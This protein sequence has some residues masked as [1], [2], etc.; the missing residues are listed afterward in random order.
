MNVLTLLRRSMTS[1][2]IDPSHL[3]AEH[4]NSFVLINPFLD[5]NGR[6]CRL[7]LNALLLKYKGVAVAFGGSHEGREEYFGIVRRASEDL[8]DDQSEFAAFI[9]NTSISRLRELAVKLQSSK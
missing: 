2:E 4:F 8:S 3:A 1:D 7:I 6:M 5:G 9:L